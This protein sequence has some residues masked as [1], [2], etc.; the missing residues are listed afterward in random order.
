MRQVHFPSLLAALVPFWFFPTVQITENCQLVLS[1]QIYRDLA[2]HFWLDL[3]KYLESLNFSNSKCVVGAL[4][5][6]VFR[7]LSLHQ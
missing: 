4:L 6:S 7:S 5:V 1:L 3:V 2:F